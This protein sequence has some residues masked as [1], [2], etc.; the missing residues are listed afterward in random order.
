MA[1]PRTGLLSM[2]LS[3][4]QGCST[5]PVRPGVFRAQHVIRAQAEASA[6]FDEVLRF[7]QDSVP[8]DIRLCDSDDLAMEVL[9]LEDYRPVDIAVHVTPIEGGGARAAFA[10]KT[11]TDIARFHLVIQAAERTLKPDSA[12][13]LCELLPFDFPEDFFQKE[14]WAA[15]TLPALL[16]QAG[17]GRPRDRQEVAA[18]LADCADSHAAC[19]LPLAEALAGGPEVA[20]GLF[21]AGFAAQYPAA[22]A[23]AHAC[24]SPG[25]PVG[26][27][28]ALGAVVAGLLTGRLP[29]AVQ[30]VLA[31]AQKSL[32][33]RVLS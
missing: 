25:L 17:S 14:E 22:V 16:R 7:F 30:T 20:E 26:V 12:P 9:V 23:L 8:A 6:L 32:G 19:R 10:H 28:E 21:E 18:A 1:P 5:A 27:A 13:P 15:T 2:T 29:A 31:R 3:S 4:E 24:A 33:G 11:M